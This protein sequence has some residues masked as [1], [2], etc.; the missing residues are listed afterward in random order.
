MGGLDRKNFI[1]EVS[2]GFEWKHFKDT[3]E[4]KQYVKDNQP[5]YNKHIP[6]VYS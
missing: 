3:D 5:Y 1:E 6:E 4:L 2:I